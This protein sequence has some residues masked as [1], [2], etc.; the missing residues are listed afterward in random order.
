MKIEVIQTTNELRTFCT[1]VS[2][3]N[4]LALDTEFVR[5]N[6]YYPHLCLI[7]IATDNRIT[8]I[9]TL[10]I[11]DFSALER[12]IYSRSITKVFHSASQDLEI[13][14]N[15]YGAIPAPVFDTQI[16]ASALGYGE[17]VSYAYLANKICG[18]TLDKSLSR[19]AWHRRPLSDEELQYAAND[20]KYLAK[21][22][23]HLGQKLESYQ[24]RHWVEDECRRL[25]VAERYK[26]EPDD[27]WKAVT[28]VSKLS[29]HQLIVL[30]QLS[31]WRERQAIK[32]NKPRQW[33]V[34]DKSLRALAIEQPKNTTALSTIEALS[35]QQRTLYSDALLNGINKARRIPE[36]QW[37]T[38]IR[39]VPLNREQ[40]ILMK[41]ALQLVRE[42]AQELDLAPSFLATRGMIEKII[43]GQRLSD[44]LQS[45]RRELI[46]NALT[47]LLR[48]NTASGI[49]AQQ[50]I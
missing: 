41:H 25:S 33:I 39:T 1:D 3:R 4:W 42:R 10:S 8:C 50:H 38:A 34:R 14:F 13:F 23:R 47:Q 37:P 17:Q 5:E 15:L 2:G 21:I 45:W 20:V 44:V 35:R 28:G 7:Q 48:E 6:T 18:I 26:I 40:R 49:D 30:Q 43:R 36:Q 11:D 24:R 32:E 16:A 29:P 19:T 12:L 31:T 27:A 9:D 22:Y 46:G